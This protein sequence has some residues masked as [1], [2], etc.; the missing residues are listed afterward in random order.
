MAA[1]EAL[2][3]DDRLNGSSPYTKKQRPSQTE[4]NSSRPKGGTRPEKEG[5]ACLTRGLCTRLTPLVQQCTPYVTTDLRVCPK[6]ALC[7]LREAK[8]EQPQKYLREGRVSTE[9]PQ[10]YLREGR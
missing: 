8:P 2:G 10:K 4:G 1:P 3:R 5:K 9:Q 6:Q 7:W